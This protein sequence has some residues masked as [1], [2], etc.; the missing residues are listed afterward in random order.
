MYIE[1]DGKD[2]VE[3]LRKISLEFK[4]K[5][6]IVGGFIR[7]YLLGVKNF[8]IDV[9][10]EGDGVEFANLLSRYLEG[11]IVIHEAF[12]TV[13]L[14]Y[15]NISIDVISARKEYYDYPAVL[16]R[17]EFSNIYDDLARRDFTI[18]TLAYDVVENKFIDYFNGIQDLKTGVIRILHSKSFIDDPTRIFRAIRYSV[19]YSFAIESET[20]R[21]LKESIDKI[22]LL[23]PDRIR[24][25][26]FLI[27]KEDKAKEMIEKVIYYGIDKIVFG[28][29]S[30]NT[31]NL[32]Y[33]ENSD[34]DIVLYR[35]LILFYLIKEKDLIK[36]KESLNISSLYLKSLED[37][38]FLCK[39]LKCK[40]KNVRKIRLTLQ[41]TKKEVIKAISTMENG[42]AQ[43]IVNTKLYITGE[44]IKN[45]G[46]KPSPLYGEL[47]DKLFEAKMKGLLNN[48]EE[49]I[50]FAK[51]LIEQ[52]KKGE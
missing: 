40:D 8:D 36:I 35:F 50:E 7:D 9:V 38:I 19:R 21:L 48:K 34:I 25:E 18:N 16:P 28:D 49:E 42:E 17:I 15:K 4:I 29:V 23:T 5:S 1:I 20:E 12:R 44:D 46:L 11:D 47:M 10:V 37:L 31:K 51:K 24:N 22:R 33:F 13:T 3:L 27:L 26:L 30:I 41:T 14:T 2:F 43:R 39:Q 6:Y 52:L 32:D 45:L